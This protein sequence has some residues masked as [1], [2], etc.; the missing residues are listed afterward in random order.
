VQRIRLGTDA[1]GRIDA[2]A[3]ESIA[4]QNDDSGFLE[5]VPFGTLPLY[6]GAVRHFRTDLVR[7]DLPATGAVRAPGEAIGTFAVEGAMDELA[8]QLGLNPLELRR[9]NEPEVDPLSG[10]PF[11]TR[12]LLDCYAQGAQAF[13]WPE[14]LPKPG[15]VRQATG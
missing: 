2:V 13:G 8:E 9:R 10:K 1:E 3:H 11:S 5:P 6:R 4:A 14:T 15:T 7:V 12:R